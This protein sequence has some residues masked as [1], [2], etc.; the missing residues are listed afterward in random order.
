MTSKEAEQ[1]LS[2]I[3]TL[4]ERSTHYTNLS[5]HAGIAAGALTLLGCVLRLQWNTPFLPTW[6]GVLVAAAGASFFFTAALARANHERFWTRAARTVV[7][8]LTPAFMASL[9]LTAVLTRVGQEPLLP[10]VWMLMWG[11]G[12]LSMSFFTPRVLSLLGLAFLG[13]GTVTLF[14]PAGYDAVKM[15]L[16]FGALHL[17]YGIVLSFAAVSRN[18]LVVPEDGARRLS[19]G[20]ALAAALPDD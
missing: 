10:G 13:A 12:A 15:G 4:M 2:A 9:V 6:I 14:L 20:S 8:A 18:A 5:G 19:Q 7:L 1:T 17:I 16:T 3:R 11:V